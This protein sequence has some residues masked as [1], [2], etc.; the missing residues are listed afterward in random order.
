MKKP[1]ISKYEIMCLFQE[2]EKQKKEELIKK[3]QQVISLE[4]KDLEAKKLA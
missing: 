1:G 3:I 2:D 4:I